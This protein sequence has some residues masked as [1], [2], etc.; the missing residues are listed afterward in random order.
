MSNKK[1]II[2]TINDRTYIINAFEGRE[3]WSYKVRL[4]KYVFPFISFW[5]NGNLGDADILEQ[6]STLLSGD[7]AK[8]VE[9]LIIELVSKVVVDGEV[10]NF[11]KEFCQNYDA[12]LLLAIE[13]IKLNYLDSFQRL[14]TNLQSV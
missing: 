9:K 12:L 8:E 2:K 10:I 3:G 13:V 5:Y 1:Q 4:S 14:V 11:D 7:N 6:L